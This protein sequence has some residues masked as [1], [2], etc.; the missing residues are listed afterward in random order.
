MI[1]R[2]RIPAPHAA[3]A[4]NPCQFGRPPNGTNQ[5]YF[6]YLKSNNCMCK[7][8]RKLNPFTHYEPTERHLLVQEQHIGDV[9]TLKHCA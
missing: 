7:T 9:Q 4:E 5:H 3:S 1:S 6:R 2:F 8:Y